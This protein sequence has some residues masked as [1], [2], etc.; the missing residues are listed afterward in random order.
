LLQHRLRDACLAFCLSLLDQCLR[1]NVFNSFVVTFL[2]VLG[3]NSTGDGFQE[4]ANYTPSLSVFI[5][6]AQLFVVQRSVD[7]AANGE[8]DYP[9]DLLDEMQYRFMT[10]GSRSPL[11]WVINLRTLRKK[12]RE[13]VTEIGHIIWTDDGELVVYKGLELTMAQLRLVVQ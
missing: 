7:A 4:P 10:L 8:V 1:G 11:E 3:V 13:D 6:I 12:L 5:K 9:A 2:A